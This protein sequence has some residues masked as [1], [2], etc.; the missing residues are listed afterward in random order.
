MGFILLTRNPSDQ[1]LIVIVDNA[2][3]IAEFRSS[4][5]AIEA[6]DKMQ[7]CKAWGYELISTMKG[8][9]SSPK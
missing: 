2:G 9:I 3:D 7:V 1:K 4:E 5:A 6:A 8:I